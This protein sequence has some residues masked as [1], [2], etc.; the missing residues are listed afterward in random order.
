[1]KY[2][3]VAIIAFGLFL[4]GCSRGQT[5]PVQPEA[6]PNEVSMPEDSMSPTVPAMQIKPSEEELSM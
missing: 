2:R 3:I 6:S 5:P 1:M 4:A